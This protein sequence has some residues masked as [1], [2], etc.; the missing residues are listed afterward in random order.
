MHS[1][2]SNIPTKYVACRQ[3]TP[4]FYSFSCI[5]NAVKRNLQSSI[6]TLEHEN[7]NITFTFFLC[8]NLTITAI[9]NAI[10]CWDISVN[11]SVLKTLTAANPMICFLILHELLFNIGNCCQI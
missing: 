4:S 10:A 7:A 8:L 6:Y 2:C 1:I 3:Y 11:S 9:K 5:L